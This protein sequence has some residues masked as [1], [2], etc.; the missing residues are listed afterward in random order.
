MYINCT[1]K[2]Q[3]IGGPQFLGEDAPLVTVFERYELQ[4]VI[5][6]I[7]PH[8]QI[9]MILINNYIMYVRT[10]HCPKQVVFDTLSGH[11]VSRFL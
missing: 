7:L 10:N 4:I 11:R 6:F 8:C 9:S 3:L 1:K 2:G 5:E